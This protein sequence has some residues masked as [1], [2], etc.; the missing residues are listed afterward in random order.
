MYYIVYG[1]LYALSLL[2]LRVLF[3]ISD[4]HILFYIMLQV[5]GENLLTVI[6]KLLFPKKQKGTKKNR[7]RVLPEFYRYLY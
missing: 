3:L 6:S 2:P 7:Q 5:T 4:L 1:F